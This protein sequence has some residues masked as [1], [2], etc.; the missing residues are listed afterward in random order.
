MIR[1]AVGAVAVASGRGYAILCAAPLTKFDEVLPSFE[2]ILSSFE[3]TGEKA[4]VTD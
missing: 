2:K 3:I 1:G 4:K